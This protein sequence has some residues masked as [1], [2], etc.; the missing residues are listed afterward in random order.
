M[1][2]RT[3]AEFDALQQPFEPIVLEIALPRRREIVGGILLALVIIFLA[4]SVG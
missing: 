2:P 1:L 4:A 3:Q